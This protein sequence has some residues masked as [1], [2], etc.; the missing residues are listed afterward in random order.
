MPSR[1]QLGFDGLA[2]L[3]RETLRWN[4][5]LDSMARENL[6]V[7]VGLEV[8]ERQVFQLAADFAHAEP[9]RDG[10]VDF[11]GLARDALAALRA[12]R[13]RASACCAGGRPA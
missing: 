2:D 9:V 11:D 12:R 13:S 3:V 8:L 6:G 10:R 7:G 5:R 4:A 1:A